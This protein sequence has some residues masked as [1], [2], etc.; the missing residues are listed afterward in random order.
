MLVSGRSTWTCER[1]GFAIG[2]YLLFL[3][4]SALRL[5][6]RVGAVDDYGDERPSSRRARDVDRESDGEL[7]G[8]GGLTLT[9][10]RGADRNASGHARASLQKRFAAVGDFHGVANC[11]SGSLQ[12]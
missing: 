10:C 9:R 3:V 12:N 4:R 1:F 8:N 2:L 6:D 11:G 7:S 5:D